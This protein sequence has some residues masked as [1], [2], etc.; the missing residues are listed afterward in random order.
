MLIGSIEQTFV[1]KSEI[2]SGKYNQN[3]RSNRFDENDFYRLKN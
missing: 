1:I 3:E 2:L